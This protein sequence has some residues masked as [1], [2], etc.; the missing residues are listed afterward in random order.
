MISAIPND[1]QV[2]A[3][4]KRGEIRSQG[5]DLNG[6]W[7]PWY[8]LHKI[9]AGLIDAYLYCGNE[10]ALEVVR[11]FSDWA[12]DVTEN[13]TDEQFARMLRCEFGGM[14]DSLYRLYRRRMERT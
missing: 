4:I 2:F 14:N 8:S 3:E 11:K 13:L 10:K 6:L 7:V 5:F 12:I 9:H 1:R